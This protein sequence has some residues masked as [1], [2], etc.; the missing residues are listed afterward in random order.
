MFMNGIKQ[1]HIDYLSSLVKEKDKKSIR[2][3]TT[4]ED[5]V[6]DEIYYWEISFKEKDKPITEDYGMYFDYRK[7]SNKISGSI[8]WLSAFFDALF[9]YK[10]LDWDKQTLYIV[11]G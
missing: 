6:K 8:T 11:G 1:K 4:F 5:Y 10:T 3:Q 2:F 7:D 9:L